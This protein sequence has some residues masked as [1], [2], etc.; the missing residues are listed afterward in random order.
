M[1]KGGFNEA[2]TSNA[3]DHERIQLALAM[4]AHTREVGGGLGLSI[5]EVV[6]KGKGHLFR[7]STVGVYMKEIAEIKNKEV[8]LKRSN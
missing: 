5:E 3:V 2:L 8:K 4:F 6:E 1:D 7:G